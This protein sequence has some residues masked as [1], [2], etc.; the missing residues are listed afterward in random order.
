MRIRDSA[1]RLLQ[2]LS[3]FSS[4]SF[5]DSR[6]GGHALEVVQLV[7]Q[8]QNE[9]SDA[10]LVLDAESIASALGMGL[11]GVAAGQCKRID[12]GDGRGSGGFSHDLSSHA[13]VEMLL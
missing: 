7:D 11:G 9:V 2:L 4:F 8:R 5:R 6:R 13:V 3:S 12:R 1:Q 10:E